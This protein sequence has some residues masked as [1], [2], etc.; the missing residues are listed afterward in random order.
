[1]LGGVGSQIHGADRDLFVKH[2]TLSD[3]VIVVYM[4]VVLCS[5]P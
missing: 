4:C 3:V 5:F 1:M 2:T